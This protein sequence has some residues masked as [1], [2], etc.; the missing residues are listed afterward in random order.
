M[1]KLLLPALASY[2][3]ALDAG[4]AT[5]VWRANGANVT[6]VGTP[7]GGAPAEVGDAALPDAT[8]ADTIGVARAAEGA[9]PVLRELGALDPEFRARLERVIE[10][11]RREFGHG[12]EVVETQRSQ[13]RQEALYAQGRTRSGPVVTW[14]RN[15]AHLGGY[16]ADLVVD[17][18][19]G[20]GAA[21]ARLAE[22]AR[23]EG[24]RTLGP[25]DPG[26]V[27]LPGAAARPAYA[28]SAFGGAFADAA[29]APAGSARSLARMVSSRG[30]APS[31]PTVFAS[32]PYAAALTS[33]GASFLA[34]AVPDEGADGPYADARG[35]DVAP[36]V[37]A[38]RA[39]PRP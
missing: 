26:H 32:S 35:A 9:P 2:L 19:L 37:A 12:V 7:V 6:A 4:T 20:G 5:L 29:A 34:P 1:T 16:A 22:L 17:N 38:G 21:Y 23:A 13:S 30:V 33:G 24:L 18:S 10:R 31:E 36:V 14:T 39:A 3:L 11:M 15:S 27:E 25:R 8:A 28:P